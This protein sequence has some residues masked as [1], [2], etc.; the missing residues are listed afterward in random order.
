[1]AGDFHGF[2]RSGTLQM[3]V[4]FL[5]LQRFSLQKQSFFLIDINFCNRTRIKEEGAKETGSFT[6]SYQLKNLRF[7]S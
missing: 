2:S 3:Y 4:M 1:M 5:K 7:L 6:P